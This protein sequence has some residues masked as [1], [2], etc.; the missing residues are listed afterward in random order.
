MQNDESLTPPGGSQRTSV[1]SW[2]EVGG[3]DDREVPMDYRY[4]EKSGSMSAKIGRN[5]RTAMRKRSQSRSSRNSVTSSNRTSSPTS[6]KVTAGVFHNQSRRSSEAS[7]TPSQGSVAKYFARDSPAVQA[8]EHVRQQASVGS[9]SPLNLGQPELSEN[10]I[11]L[12]HQLA[13]D[14]SMLSYLPRAELN[15]PRIHSS[16]L[17]PFPGIAS[18]ERR[19]AD[20]TTL[21]IPSLVHQISDSA[22]PSQQRVNPAIDPTYA[23]PLPPASPIEP[24]RTSED[25]VGKRSWLTKAFGQ[26]TSPR[27]S[28][29]VSRTSSIP[30]LGDPALARRKPSA[31]GHPSF[32]IPA[33]ESDPFAGPPMPTTKPSRHHSASPSVSMVPEVNEEGSRF[34]RFTT[35]T[36]RVDEASPFIEEEEPEINGETIPQKSIDVL[37]RMDDLLALAPD[38]PARPDVLD[39]PPRKLLLATHVLQVVNVNVRTSVAATRLSFDRRPKTAFSSSLTIFWSSPSHSSL[40]VLALHST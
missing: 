11:L 3:P 32:A 1:M 40:P 34:T 23:L 16:K 30:E 8:G 37:N 18:L 13:A 21:N 29:S 22:V 19:S 14:P 24:R 26:Q 7:A 5:I 9:L 6:P 2:E 27:S 25:S 39:D 36:Q 17:S 20:S 4:N 10:S 15:D 35:A 28:S 12:Q 33:S 31:D 38:D